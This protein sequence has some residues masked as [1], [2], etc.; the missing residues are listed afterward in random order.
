[1][2][3]KRTTATEETV[4]N[5]VEKTTEP[6]TKK[7]PQVSKDTEVLVYNATTSSFYYSAKK[8]NGYLELS[9]FM[10][11]DWMTVEDLTV[12]KNTDRNVF[13]NGWLWIEEE[14]V[15]KY[16]G[17]EKEMTGILLEDKIDLLFESDPNEILETI[18]T[19]TDTT[20]EVVATVLRQR[21]ANGEIADIHLIKA[22]EEALK[23]DKV[24]SVLNS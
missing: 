7:R 6:V 19:L 14:D 4:E 20:K 1:M 18:P 2:A 5:K 24:H 13:K 15:V 22:F 3:V 21:Y 17:L 9:N 16:L 12:L 10:D 8:G 23:I 11:S